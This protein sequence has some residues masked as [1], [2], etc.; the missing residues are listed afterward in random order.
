MKRWTALL[1][2]PLLLAVALALPAT[3]V[4]D[5]TYTFKVVDQHC[6]AGGHNIYFRVSLTADGSTY[7]T[8]LT[9]KST[10]QYKSG[11]T[12][13]DSYHWKI[14]NSKFTKNG[15][16]HTIDYSYTHTDN[17]SPYKW[18]IVSELKALEGQHYLA[19]KILTSKPC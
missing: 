4:A 2:S 17:S 5:G 19:S 8:H 6:I 13:H 15:Q 14:N 12:W 7:A 16:S 3:T 9:I 18:R 10:S 11:G 1:W